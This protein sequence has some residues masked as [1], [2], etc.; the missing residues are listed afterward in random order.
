MP[1]ICINE[2]DAT[3]RQQTLIGIS[4][5]LKRST[6][7][8][9]THRHNTTLATQETHKNLTTTSE[10]PDQSAA[11]EYYCPN[12]NDHI[13]HFND[14]LWVSCDKYRDSACELYWLRRTINSTSGPP[15]RMLDHAALLEK[16]LIETSTGP[17]G[18]KFHQHNPDDYKNED[19]SSR[20]T[21][22][23]PP[24]G[25]GPEDFK[26]YNH[27][28]LLLVLYMCFYYLLWSAAKLIY[29]S[30]GRYLV[31]GEAHLRLFRQIPAQH[32]VALGLVRSQQT[33]AVLAVRARG[34]LRL[35][36]RTTRHAESSVSKRG[37]TVRVCGAL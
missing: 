2:L 12:I 24:L 7:R 4:S 19:G 15:K 30:F 31:G 8:V 11:M 6:Q 9:A 17:R 33:L 34:S 13:R 29:V 37:G 20:G 27:A 26:E 25:H 3:L 36:S 22:A 28:R 14:R 5:T 35:G 23:N 16:N 21:N 18:C 1:C 32:A 10:T